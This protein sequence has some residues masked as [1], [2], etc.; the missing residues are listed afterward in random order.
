[1]PNNN[2]KA[3]S[4]G[5]KFNRLTVIKLHHKDKRWRR[6]YLCQCDCGN[7][8]VIQGT[9]LKNGNT[10]SCGCLSKETKAATALP[11]SLGA[12]RQVILQNYKRGT[13]GKPWNLSET[14]FYN[15]SQKPCFYCGIL[16]AQT[17]KGQGNG[18]DFIY[19]GI[20]RIDSRKGYKIDNVVPCCRKCNV[21]KNDMSLKD[22]QEWAIK[23]GKK[24]MAKQWSI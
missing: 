7:K 6:Y 4:N 23:L 16:P 24:A 14:E 12:M 17:K 2:T 11:G 5:T 20:D 10:K 8:K 1:M 13:K 18:H 19:N 9:L 15:I 3:F 22:F 21:A